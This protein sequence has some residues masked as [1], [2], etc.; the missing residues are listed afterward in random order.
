MYLGS[1]D[2]NEKLKPISKI[3]EDFLKECRKLGIA[4]TEYPFNKVHTA[5]K[6][7][8]QYLKNLS[9]T[10][11]SEV[12]FARYGQDAGRKALNSKPTEKKP[13][14]RPFE[15]VELDAHKCDAMFVIYIEAPDGKIRTLELERIWL[16]LLVDVG[17]RAVLG[18][19]ISLNR[20]CDLTDVMKATQNSIVPQ[21]R[22]ALTIP[23]LTYP[24]DGGLPNQVIP[25][26][27]W[28]LFDLL[29]VDNAK[30]HHSEKLHNA[31]AEKIQCFINIG[32]AS[33]PEGRAIV[34][35]LFRTLTDRGFKR[36]P[37]T[38][39]SN[40]QDPRRADGKKSRNIYE[41]HIDE[42]EQL[43]DVIVA[44]YNRNYHSSIFC[45]PLEYLRSHDKD[46]T[47]LARRVPYLLQNQWLVTEIVE[48]ATIRANIATGQRPYIQYLKVCY[49]SHLLSSNPG[50]ANKK[51]IIK[52]NIDD[53]RTIKAYYKNGSYLGVLQA[54]GRWSLTKHSIKTRKIF[55]RLQLKGSLLSDIPDPIESVQIYLKER[56]KSSKAHANQYYRVMRESG[57]DL[58]SGESVSSPLKTNEIHYEDNQKNYTP[59]REE[60]I[61]LRNTIMD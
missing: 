44:Q 58:Q 53:L 40:P 5:K 27:A 24:A 26:C 15:R 52:I 22:K 56:A 20:E 8:Y 7:L 47:Q 2:K 14:I 21:E 30:I 11:F 19:S 39:G 46:K 18:Y 54:R 3:H 60:W 34:E 36:T 33:Q 38:T 29:A 57:F 23:E 6:S 45:S 4:P 41:F 43:L 35:R 59:D 49:T 61:S 48:E 12:A 17:S 31:L 55:N 10:R 51:V 42:G 1:K 28:R 9:H 16:V 50:L 37:T 13:I 32:K 25:T